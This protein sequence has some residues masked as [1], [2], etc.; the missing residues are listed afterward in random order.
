[1]FV[2]SIGAFNF[3]YSIKVS[4]HFIV[5]PKLYLRKANYYKIA[6]D[7]STNC[8]IQNKSLIFQYHTETWIVG[9][10]KL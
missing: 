5:L 4:S 1:M 9:I 7:K 10:V 6:K 8:K 2:T 3:D